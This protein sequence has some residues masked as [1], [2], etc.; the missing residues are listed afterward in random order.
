MVRVDFGQL[1]MN[2]SF[3]NRYYFAAF[4][5]GTQIRDADGGA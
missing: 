1:T 3:T 5:F 2:T 4:Y